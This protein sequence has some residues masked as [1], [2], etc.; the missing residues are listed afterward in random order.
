M[1]LNPHQN[2]ISAR[3]KGKKRFSFC[4]PAQIGNSFLFLATSQK[5][6]ASLSYPHRSSSNIF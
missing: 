3:L 6:K 5:E 4:A 2:F 1:S